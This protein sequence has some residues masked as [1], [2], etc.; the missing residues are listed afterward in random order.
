MLKAPALTQ[1]DDFTIYGDDT[2]FFRFFPLANN[3][4]LRMDED[5]EPV[6][7]LLKYELSDQDRQR[8]PQLPQGGGYLSFDTSYGA[9]EEQLASLRVALQPRVDAEWQRL[10]NG[11]EEERAL[12]G[13]AG[14]TA[15]PQVE[16]GTPTYTSGKVK[17]DTPRSSALIAGRV[18]EHLDVHRAG[19][20]GLGRPARAARPAR[21]RA[22]PV[23]RARPRRPRFRARG[24][25]RLGRALRRPRRA[26]R[27][28]R[29]VRLARS[30]APCPSSPAPPTSRTRAGRTPSRWRCTAERTTSC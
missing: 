5:G 15:P 4:G 1:I 26:V 14:T 3:P 6:I 24:D 7:L 12:P 27:G 21:S 11:T 19:S 29:R 23:L 28:E 9:T 30:R 8:N 17:I 25:G 10:S 13:V 20:A 2:Y 22:A 16:L 18:A